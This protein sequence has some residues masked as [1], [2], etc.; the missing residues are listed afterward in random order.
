MA[1]EV[2]QGWGHVTASGSRVS[3][4]VGTQGASAVED[5]IRRSG[6][7][8]ILVRGMGRSYGDA[9][10]LA[11]GDVVELSQVSRLVRIDDEA[12]TVRA[13]GGVTIDHLLRLLVPRG[14]FLPVTPGTRHVSLGG[15]IAADVHGKNH[16]ADGSIG[17]HLKTIELVSP[18]GRHTLFPQGPSADVF[19]ATVGGMGL[20]GA[21]IEAELGLIPIEAASMTVRT[22]RLDDLDDLLGAMAAR[23]SAHRYSVAWLDTLAPGA[24]LGRSLLSLGHHSTQAEVKALARG[25]VRA[26]HSQPERSSSWQAPPSLSWQA[27]TSLPVPRL[28]DRLLN[29]SSARVLNA[30]RFRRTPTGPDPK[31]ASLN[32]FFY[33]LDAL[34]NWFRLYGRRGLLQYQFVVPFG[35]ESV[36][37][38][39]LEQ[40]GGDEFP[41]FLA[42]L[43]TMG[44]RDLAPLSFPGPGWTLALDLAGGNPD[45]GPVL[46]RMDQRVAEAGGRVYLAKDCRMRPDL[47][48][49]MYPGLDQW[50]RTRAVVD[51]LGL[52]RSDLAHRLGLV[53]GPTPEPLDHPLG[54][55]GKMRR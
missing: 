22:E 17:S 36:V 28:P 9:A 6:G 15:A 2:L 50:R 40:L 55:D 11:G 39:C 14:W 8:G 48:S 18:T 21:I 49:A 30:W 5:A 45:L 51:P 32:A 16:H 4:P 24:R 27:P 12:A 7:R 37:Q 23:R 35:A 46:D 29:A 20:T 44:P 52:F 10:Q 42:V 1:L 54:G 19:W 38:D 3:R 33:P 31:L 47:V 41:I 25:L 53:P 34:S 43:K 26:K 13:G